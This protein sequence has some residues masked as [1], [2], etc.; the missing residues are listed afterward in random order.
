MTV[1]PRPIHLFAGRDWDS[2]DPSGLLKPVLAQSR[3][4]APRIAYIGAASGDDAGFF[5][6]IARLFRA[7]GAGKVVLAPTAGSGADSEEALRAIRESDF[8]F[9]SGGDVEEG[10]RVLRRRH[11]DRHLRK[12]YMDGKPVFGLSAGAIMM[13]RCWARWDEAKE[14]SRADP[15]PC[16]ALAPVICDVHEEGDDWP[17]LRSLLRALEP[18]AVGFGIPTGS[19]LRVSSNGHVR[20][21]G[22]PVVRLRWNGCDIVRLSDLTSGAIKAAVIPSNY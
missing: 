20:A 19:V 3:A 15:F 14:D 11:L 17:E 6:W 4:R 9:V 8:V 13:S 7:A 12:L 2:R 10:M 1:T 21:L 16:L 18:P 22:G 5:R